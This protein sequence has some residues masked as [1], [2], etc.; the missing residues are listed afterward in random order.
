MV[1]R[2]IVELH[3]ASEPFAVAWE[4]FGAAARDWDGGEPLREMHPPE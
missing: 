2:H 4:G 3:V 1:G